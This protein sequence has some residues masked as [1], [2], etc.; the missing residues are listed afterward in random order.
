MI[1]HLLD[2]DRALMVGAAVMAVLLARRVPAHRP[3]AVFLGAQTAVMLAR[4]ALLKLYLAPVIAAAGGDVAAAVEPA[5][6]T[7]WALIAGVT[8]NAGWL[9]WAAGLAMLALW[10]FARDERRAKIELGI[11]SIAFKKDGTAYL[12]RRE[13]K[14]WMIVLP[15]LT[16]LAAVA[17]IAITYP[18]GRP[19][20]PQLFAGA[21][22]ASVLVGLG[23][24][25]AWQA[26][27]WGKQSP[28]FSQACVVGLLVCDAV[29]LAGP[30]VRGLFSSWH[31]SQSVDLVEYVALILAQGGL[32]WT[33]RS[34]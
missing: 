17:F 2:I 10:S 33:T 8:F 4:W 13:P 18:E 29:S 19:F 31:L 34:R 28:S 1:P 32:L 16:W 30:M 27:S 25:A 6:L 20:Y 15:A 23:A 22:L 9:T 7:G 12:V 26:R 21:Q 24:F 11:S 14:T 5:P 3:V